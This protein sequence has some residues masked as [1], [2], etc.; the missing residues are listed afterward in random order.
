MRY[1][2]MFGF[3]LFVSTG[4]SVCYSFHMFYFVLCGDFNFISSYSMVETSYNTGCPR[5]KGQYSGRS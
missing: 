4:L 2:N 1:V 3:L 5:R